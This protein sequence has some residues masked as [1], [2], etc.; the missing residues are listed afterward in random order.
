LGSVKKSLAADI[1]D[2][3]GAWLVAAARAVVDAAVR[4]AFWRLRGYDV[5]GRE[6]DAAR[7]ALVRGELAALEHALPVHVDASV[8]GA[9]LLQIALLCAAPDPDPDPGRL[10]CV[11]VLL[12]ADADPNRTHCGIPPLVFGAVGGNA[13]AVRAL[14]K[15]GAQCA[16]FVTNGI[17][18]GADAPAL[19]LGAS[20]RESAETLAAYR[21]A[22]G[23]CGECGACSGAITRECAE[24]LAEYRCAS[25]PAYAA[26]KCERCM[27]TRYCTRACQRLDWPVHKCEC[28]PHTLD[29]ALD[30]S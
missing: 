20:A 28:A 7:D 5:A 25:C 22:C 6:L 15:R 19:A 3:R 4:D 13:A 10:G 30:A 17:A 1:E 16:P 21:M 29:A 26:R 27:R 11:R 2:E 14:I 24:T 8:C 12:D 23:A 9:T 18:Y